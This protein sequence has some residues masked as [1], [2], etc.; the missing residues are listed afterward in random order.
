MCRT[1]NLFIVLS[2]TVQDF[3]GNR[4][5]HPFNKPCITIQQ[6]SVTYDLS[7]HLQTNQKPHT[8]HIIHIIDQ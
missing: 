1:S 8:Y 7:K 2:V 4:K 6:L 5:L 3:L